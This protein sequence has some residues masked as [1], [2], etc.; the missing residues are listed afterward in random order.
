V[1]WAEVETRYRAQVVKHY[2]RLTLTG[3]PERDPNLHE[4]ALDKIFVRL[5]IEIQRHEQDL[6]NLRV[7]WKQLDDELKTNSSNDQ[8]VDF[9][10]RVQQ[11]VIEAEAR[12]RQIAIRV[13]FTSH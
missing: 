2:N 10:I 1:D 5:K 4:L 11:R 7:K 13:M 12:Q 8:I 9:S 3:L 6:A